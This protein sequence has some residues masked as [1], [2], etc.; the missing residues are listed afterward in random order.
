MSDGTYKTS[1]S[2]TVNIDFE[3]IFLTDGIKQLKIRYNPQ[4]GSMNQTILEM[5]QDTIGGK[6]PFFMRNGDTKYFTFSF[7]GLITYNMDEKGY[8]DE[9]FKQDSSIRLGTEA[10]QSVVE[11]SQ[12]TTAQSGYNFARERAFREKVLEWLNN[13]EIKLYRSATEGNKLIRCMNVNLSSNA[14]LSRLVWSFTAQAVEADD[15]TYEKLIKY[16]IYKN[17]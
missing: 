4:L 17:I 12:S 13:G 11:F 5:K 2:V 16:N 10:N 14:Q 1:K 15:C 3:D 9:E 7:G 8:F 6:Y